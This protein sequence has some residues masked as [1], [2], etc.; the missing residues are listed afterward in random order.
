MTTASA[1]NATWQ[2]VLRNGGRG[3]R[4]GQVNRANVLTTRVGLRFKDEVKEVT[5]K[6][7]RRVHDGS[8]ITRSWFG[9]LIN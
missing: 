8:E 1:S 5:K 2:E 7:D 3:E 6:M 9:V 4:A